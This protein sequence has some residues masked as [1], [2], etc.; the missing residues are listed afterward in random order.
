MMKKKIISI[1][2][3]MMLLS[4]LFIFGQIPVS[5]EETATIVLN[6]GT[7]TI[8]GDGGDASI[9]VTANDNFNVDIDENGEWV[10]FKV[11]YD[12]NN[13]DGLMDCSWARISYNGFLRDEIECDTGSTDGYLSFQLFCYS[14]NE[15]DVELEGE[16]AD[17]I[18]TPAE[19]NI[20][21]TDTSSNSF[22]YTPP[23]NHAPNEPDQ[24]DGKDLIYIG[25]GY[26]VPK[27]VNAQY[28]TSATDS[29]GDYVSIFIN[30]GNDD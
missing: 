17:L 4:T 12:I 1:T 21:G 28:A 2:S 16:Y 25:L 5:S 13:I 6:C 3:I 29:D 23:V 7:I 8:N 27:S 18:N 22:L 26:F 19:W 14:S 20:Y 30:F 10:K 9:T 11:Y 15:I 24:P